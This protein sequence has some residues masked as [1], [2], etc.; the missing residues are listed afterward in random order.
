MSE[1]VKGATWAAGEDAGSSP[2]AVGAI[3]LRASIF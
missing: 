1:A 2:N 3:G